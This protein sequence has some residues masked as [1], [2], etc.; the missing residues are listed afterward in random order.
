MANSENPTILITGATVVTTEELGRAMIR[1]ASE[2]ATKRVLENRDL[3][4]LGTQ[5]DQ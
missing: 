3:R 4:A 2:G 5:S 1:A